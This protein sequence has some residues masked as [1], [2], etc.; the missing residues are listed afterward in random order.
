MQ[1]KTLYDKAVANFR[2]AD[3]ILLNLEDDEEQLNFAGY[4]LQQSLELALKY[5]LEQNGVEY[6]KTHD[7]ERLIKL[8]RENDVD[9]MVSDYIDDHA[10]MFSSWESKARYITG[11]QLETRKLTRARDEVDRFLAAIAEAE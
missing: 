8:G 9:L 6:P 1:A 5:L 11:Y 2:L 10:E 3:F 7:I 4:H